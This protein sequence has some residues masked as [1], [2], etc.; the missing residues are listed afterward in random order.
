LQALRTVSVDP[1][2]FESFATSLDNDSGVDFDS[3]DTVPQILAPIGSAAR[4]H[5]LKATHK[6]HRAVRRSRRHKK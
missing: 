3:G 6:S 2:N 1:R 5:S 4:L